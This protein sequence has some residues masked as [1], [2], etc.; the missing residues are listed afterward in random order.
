MARHWLQCRWDIHF[1]ALTREFQ[2]WT[3]HGRST[4]IAYD[5]VPMDFGHGDWRK[6]NSL[7]LGC[8]AHFGTIPFRNGHMLRRFWKWFRLY[9]NESIRS[10][11]NLKY[12]KSM[13]YSV[14]FGIQLWITEHFRQCL[15]VTEKCWHWTINIV[16]HSPVSGHIDKM[17]PKF[18]V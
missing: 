6:L 7:G 5:A 14:Q 4:M 8:V 1:A 15:F 9:V 12:K 10:L 16:K 3:K 17:L 13:K 18:S 11:E 2:D